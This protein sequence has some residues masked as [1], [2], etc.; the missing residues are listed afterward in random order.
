MDPSM[1]KSEIVRIPFGKS[2]WGDDVEQITLVNENGM[3]MNVLTIGTIV[4]SLELPGADG[5]LTDIILGF[6]DAESYN[7]D[8]PYFGCVAGRFANRINKGQFTI[9]GKTYQIPCNEVTRALHGGNKG[10][11]KRIWTAETAMLPEGPSVELTYVSK[12]GEE[13]FPGELTAKVR[14]TLTNK[15]EW[16]IDYSATTDKATVVNLT[17]HSYFNLSGD[18]NSCIND[19]IMQI[20]ADTITAVD[21]NLIPTGELMP[22][23]N[24]PMDFRT[25]C[26]IGER[27]EAP[28]EQ[29]KITGGYDHN[30]VVRGANGKDLLCAAMARD[31]KS[32]RQV[33]V[34]TTEPGIQFYGGNFLDG[35]LKGKGATY[36]QRNGF[37]LETQHFPD[38]PNQD[39]F[40]TT[41][42]RPGD[43]WTSQ[44]IYRFSC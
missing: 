7:Q 24:T 34:W 36:A 4:R 17:Q 1:K 5:S 3:R 10:F 9:D 13:G 43:V 12:D 18:F 38:S 20:N 23:E 27:V 29:L 21:D 41:L 31:P 22:V 30:F 2:A 28:F 6:D 19:H 26:P 33:E 8:S 32:G 16:Q 35:S 14:Y 25:P 44:T 39:S 37:C 40:P 42:L 11:D 15:N